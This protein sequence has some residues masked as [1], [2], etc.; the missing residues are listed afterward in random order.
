M[1][2]HTFLPAMRLASHVLL[3]S[4]GRKVCFES[5]QQLALEKLT[6]LNRRDVSEGVF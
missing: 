2:S 3:L 5:P 4:H 1:V 6:E